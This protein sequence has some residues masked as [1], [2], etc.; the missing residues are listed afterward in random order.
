M[1]GE[2]LCLYTSSGLFG[3]QALSEKL[4]LVGKCGVYT[5]YQLSLHAHQGGQCILPRGLQLWQLGNPNWGDHLQRYPSPGQYSL[6]C[7]GYLASLSSAASDVCN[8]YAQ[9]GVFSQLSLAQSDTQTML[10]A[11]MHANTYACKG[12]T[13]AAAFG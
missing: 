13:T 4:L 7:L 10:H 8:L 3:L 1:C 5:T 2:L 9:A 6:P 12:R 11:H